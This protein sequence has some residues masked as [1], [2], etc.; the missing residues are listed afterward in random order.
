MKTTQHCPVAVNGT[1][2]QVP[3]GPG[4]FNLTIKVKNTIAGSCSLNLTIKANRESRTPA[5]RL[6]WGRIQCR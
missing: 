2:G 1:N 5:L 4:S 3:A 6:E